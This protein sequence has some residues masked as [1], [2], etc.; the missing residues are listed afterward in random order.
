MKASR[1]PNPEGVFEVSIYPPDVLKR[2]RPAGNEISATIRVD[3]GTEFMS[4]DFGPMGLAFSVQRPLPSEVSERS[5]APE[6]CRRKKRFEDSRQPDHH[7][8]AGKNFTRQ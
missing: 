3:P 7:D 2:G 5:L 6:P 8:R 1:F 4:R